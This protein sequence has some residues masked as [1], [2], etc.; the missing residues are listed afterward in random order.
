MVNDMHSNRKL[1]GYYTRQLVINSVSW[2]KQE[3]LTLYEKTRFTN[4]QTSEQNSVFFPKCL[5]GYFSYT[6]L[7]AVDLFS[8]LEYEA[9]RGTQSLY[10]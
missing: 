5:F 8:R 10:K 3:M 4:G 1:V 9:N 6:L 2:L 7:Q